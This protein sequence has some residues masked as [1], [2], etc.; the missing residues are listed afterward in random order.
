MKKSETQIMLRLP[1]DT[2]RQLKVRCVEQNISMQE[3]LVKII[4][5]Y[6]EKGDPGDVLYKDENGNI[7]LFVKNKKNKKKDNDLFKT[8]FITFILL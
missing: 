4:K 5:E 3:V 7:A 1:M 2:K 8:K 6:L